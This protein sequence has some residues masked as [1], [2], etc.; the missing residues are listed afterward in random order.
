MNAFDDYD[1]VE[2]PFRGMEVD[3]Q[4]YEDEYEDN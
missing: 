1:T 2:D 4:D 3:E